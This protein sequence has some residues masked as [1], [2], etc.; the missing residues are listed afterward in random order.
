M[1]LTVELVISVVALGCSIYAVL[2]TRS[3]NRLSVVP[4]LE[5]HTDRN[6]TN[7]GITFT[8]TLKNTGVGPAAIQDRGFLLDGKRHETKLADP[9]PELA[10]LCLQGKTP[11]VLKRHGSPGIGSSI[12]A[13][14]SICIAE[15]FIPGLKQGQED[16][17][18]QLLRRVDFAARYRSLHGESFLFTTAD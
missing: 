11:F 4:H 1:N 12:P 15:L 8:F 17:I 13:G 3:H 6:R 16:A 9:V 10:E 5:W 2:L 7:E 18:A 14:Q